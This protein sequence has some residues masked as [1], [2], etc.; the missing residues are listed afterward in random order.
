MELNVFALKGS[1][2]GKMVS[3][4][5]IES[6][7]AAEHLGVRDEDEVIAFTPLGHAIERIEHSLLPT[8]HF[9][10]SAR[11]GYN[12]E[13]RPN[14]EIH[15]IDNADH[16]AHCAK[17]SAMINRKRLSDLAQSRVQADVKLA[18]LFDPT[19]YDALE[20][21]TTW[22]RPAN[23]N[24]VKLTDQNGMNFTLPLG[25]Y[26]VIQLSEFSLSRYDVQSGLWPEHCLYAA[27]A[28]ISVWN[29]RYGRDSFDTETAEIR[30]QRLGALRSL[31]V[32]VD[33]LIKKARSQKEA[34]TANGKWNVR[35][36][37]DRQV[38]ERR[39]RETVAFIRQ[40]NARLAE[41][42][43]PGV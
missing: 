30:A 40:A 6:A 4:R 22:V 16:V 25:S 34:L 39:W 42:A 33:K 17:C 24:S 27:Q 26:R 13:T 9:H 20:T 12:E 38:F 23:R 7:D 5:L 18:Y 2:I 15:Q 21:Y 14:E 41:I 43:E 1:G 37:G 36:S 8:G 11:G 19:S 3:R 32:E 10:A 35:S 29:E 31:S 28:L